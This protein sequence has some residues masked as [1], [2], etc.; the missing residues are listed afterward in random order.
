MHMPFCWFCREAAH[1]LIISSV[2]QSIIAER[3]EIFP[4]STSRPIQATKLALETLLKKND[5]G[6]YMA[7]KEA[8][9]P[10]Q[11]SKT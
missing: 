7:I 1:L 11:A 2:C 5:P 3:K 4:L 9:G 8:M 6:I 10:D